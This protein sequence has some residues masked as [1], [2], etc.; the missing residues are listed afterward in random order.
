MWLSK[1]VNRSSLFRF[2]LSPIREIVLAHVPDAVSGVRFLSWISPSAAFLGSIVSSGVTHAF[3]D[4][5]A[6]TNAS[7]FSEACD[8]DLRPLPSRGCVS[9]SFFNDAPLRSPGFRA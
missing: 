4:F 7:D 9:I 3:N 5:G 1:L 2:A 6:T 8:L